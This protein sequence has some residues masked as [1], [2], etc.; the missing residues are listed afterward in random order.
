MG[1]AQTLSGVNVTVPQ[2]L[3]TTVGNNLFHSFT[4]FNIATGQMVEFTGSD[5]L[6]NVISRVTSTDVTEIE[7]TLK[8]SIANA[9]FYLINPNG[10]TFGANA[11]VD[12]PGAFHV[13]TAD[14]IDFL[15]N[16]GVFY[17]DSTQTSSL[18]SEAPAV[19]GFLESSAANNGLIGINASQLT[20]KEGQALDVVAGE[21]TVENGAAITAPAGEIR[22]VALQDAGSVSL[23]KTTDGALP[24]PT[25]TPST[26]N[27][28]TIT[29]NSSDV[30]T[31]GNGGGRIALWGGNASFSNSTAW[32]DNKGDT[33]ASS[34]KGVAIH[35]YSL[36][37]DKT[38]VSFDAEGA[39]NSG[40]VTVETTGPLSVVNGGFIKTTTRAQGD[41][42]NVTVTADTLKVDRK[43][44]SSI[45]GIFS[46][47]STGSSGSA[48]TVTVKAGTLDILR[49]GVIKSSTIAPGDAGHI[50][51]TA[52]TLTIDSQNSPVNLYS[53][54]YSINAGGNSGNSGNLTVKAGTLDI[55][56]GGVVSSSTFGQGD[57][58]SVTVTADDTLKIDSSLRGGSGIFSEA[59]LLSAGNAG[60]VTVKAGTLNILTGGAVS[61]STFSQGGAGTV[62]IQAD[63]VAVLNRSIISSASRG[64]D[65][66]GKTG[67]VIVTA[68]NWLHLADVSRI[69]IENEA[70][71][72][73]TA[74]A[75]SIT[76]GF[77]TVTAPDIDMKNSEITSNS[78]GNIA[79]GNI[80]VNFSHWLAMD[81]SFI[82]TT[83]N[84]GNGGSITINGGE[85]IT[86]QN[87]GFRTTVSGANSNGGDI[88][89]TANMLIMDAGLIQ[90]NAVGG[91]G[92]NI[93]LK[94][95]T[96]IPSGNTLILG[97]AP[98]SWQ[99]FI[100]GFNVIQAASQAG[101]SGTVSVTAPQLNLSGIIANL[102]GSQ[103][104][105]SL[106]SQDYC[107]LGAG[108]SLTRKGN[109]GL[110]PKS[111]NQILF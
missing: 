13:S 71:A 73:T 77:I 97:G 78:T 23:E 15:N 110:K 85:L 3:G 52:N 8:S 101:I 7:G 53:G 108:S 63:T 22:L 16:G 49:G 50:T 106:I 66:S 99:P 36:N 88:F 26:T 46:E 10:I 38:T 31:T 69:S 30:R 43:G 80:T 21:I 41:A 83:A 24:L 61:S 34:A 98:V 42:G 44:A 62:T 107:G 68:G 74:A 54:V 33:D 86:L 79:A 65:S 48:G 56:N 93:T 18:S 27:A 103:F 76:P 55:L 84:T 40:D 51:V 94:L 102:G 4:E 67:D 17:A 20:V 58:A 95:D 32:A 35:A 64:A 81:P 47:A 6:Q 9:A 100:P 92:G 12:V 5:A 111:G 59:Q 91:S 25:A 29:V 82:S 14:K 72:P 70:S 90:A 39:G 1:V 57:A 37:V 105:T 104:D 28:G 87:S 109:G 96:L 2:T 89:T 11:Q 45:T 19:F 75:S 60:N